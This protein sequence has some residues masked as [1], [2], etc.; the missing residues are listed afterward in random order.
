LSTS[1]GII[2]Q[3]AADHA[4]ART[5]TQEANAE[6]C[7]ASPASTDAFRGFLIHLAAL[8]SFLIIPNHPFSDSERE[9]IF[10]RDFVNEV[11]LLRDQLLLCSE[12]LAAFQ[13][14]QAPA[15]EDRQAVEGTEISV[16]V[17]FDASLMSDKADL[18]R[19][20]LEDLYALCESLIESGAVRFKVWTSLSSVI[21]RELKRINANVAWGSF[22]HCSFRS[23]APTQLSALTGHVSPEALAADV[24]S[25]FSSLF[26]MLEL[27]Q[28]VQALLAAD[29][30]LKLTLPLFTLLREE[31]LALLE[32]I[33]NRTLKIEGLDPAL[34]EQLDGLAYALRMELRKAFEHELVGLT[35]LRHPQHLYA[36]VENAHGLLRDC[37]QQSISSLALAFDPLF[38]VASIFSSFRTKLEQSLLLREEL[39]KVLDMV[40]RASDQRDER[41]LRSLMQRLTSFRESGLRFLMYKDWESLERFTEEL[42]A[43]KCSTDMQPILHRFHAFLETLFSQVSMRAVLADYPFHPPAPEA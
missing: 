41:A 28:R 35:S 43:A 2:E 17:I 34:H 32:L 29:E 23:H 42:G 5:I 19:E 16:A 36:K 12:L 37:F 22:H 26:G 33:G 13:S 25:I 31:S 18:I 6:V 15:I 21:R 9:K 10:S 11:R 4:L 39:W 1:V 30:P 7:L 38:E 3:N 24:S 14:N 20:S 40:R 27:L 8:R